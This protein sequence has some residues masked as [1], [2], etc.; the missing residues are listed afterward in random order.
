MLNAAMLGADMVEV[1]LDKFERDAN[2][3]AIVTAKRKP[4]LFSCRRPEDGGEWA[5][6]EDERLILL[7]SAVMAKADYVE[8]ELDAA[9]QIR[10]FPGCQRVVSYTNLKETPSDIDAIYA[11]LQTKKPDVIKLTC[12]TRTP[13][14]AWP[15]IQ[16]LNKPLYR[17]WLGRGNAGLMLA[18]LPPDRRTLM[19][20]HSKGNGILRRP[21]DA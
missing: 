9:D 6:T 5:G 13:E 1:R 12:G 16:L 18:L 4:V 19:S 21:A 15:L 7:R 20:R 11:Q 17:P 3:G 8:V 2:L 14:E 10:P